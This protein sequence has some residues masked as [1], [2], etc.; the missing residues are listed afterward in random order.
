[1][2]LVLE[3]I[4]RQINVPTQESPRPQ[5]V[6]MV[7]DDPPVSLIELKELLSH[8]IFDWPIPP[9]PMSDP[10]EEVSF[11]SI[12]DF[13]GWYEQN[14]TKFSGPQQEALDTLVGARRMIEDG[15]ACKR[16]G[17]EYAANEYYRTFWTNNLKTDMMSTLLSALGAKKVLISDFIVYLAV[18]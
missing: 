14:K 13:V 1:M 15:C 10:V 16:H 12:F 7:Q 9:K 11:P 5:T 2:N 17:R 18:V 8:I 6:M 3:R 4:R